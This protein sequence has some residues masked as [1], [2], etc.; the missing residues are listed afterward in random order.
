MGFGKLEFSLPG[1]DEIADTRDVLEFCLDG[2]RAAHCK[3][4]DHDIVPFSLSGVLSDLGFRPGECVQ[5]AALLQFSGL[6]VRLNRRTSG[7]G[8]FYWYVSSMKN[9]K[10]RFTEEV[11]EAHWLRVNKDYDRTTEIRKL[12]EQLER[13]TN[14]GPVTSQVDEDFLAEIDARFSTVTEQ[15]DAAQ[16][17]I[18]TLGEERDAAQVVISTL[19]ER[20]T[21]LE[22]E[23]A[24]KPDTASV[25]KSTFLERLDAKAAGG[26]SKK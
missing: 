7:N 23:L 10:V 20:I 8:P 11:V 25:V 21:A 3:G 19:N 2:I 14:S 18:V 12:R 5:L 4:G 26:N 6:L 16:A 13:V 22:A 9:L 15:R 24:A 1:S 17:A